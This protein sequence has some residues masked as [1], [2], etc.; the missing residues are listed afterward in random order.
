VNFEFDDLQY[1]F[2]DLLYGQSALSLSV[3]KEIEA[4]IKINGV[5]RMKATAIPGTMRGNPGKGKV[6]LTVGARTDIL[7]SK[8]V[9]FQGGTHTFRITAAFTDYPQEGSVYSNNGS[10]FTVVGVVQAEDGGLRIATNKHPAQ[11]IH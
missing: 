2:G 6:K 8:P 9:Y 10:Q 11:T 7:N 3:N 1:S 4:I 5:E